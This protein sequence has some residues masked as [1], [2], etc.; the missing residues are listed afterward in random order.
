FGVWFGMQ[1]GNAAGTEY[2]AGYIIEKSLSIDNLFVFVIIMNTFA[3]P[4]RHQ[5]KVLVFGIVLALAMRAVFIAVGAS[6]IS[7]FSFTFLGFGL[8]LLYT[9]VQL[10]RHR[11]EDPDIE[12][13]LMVRGARRLLP[14]SDGYI[15]GRLMARES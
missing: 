5:H 1:Y 6:L 12:S 14:V 13:N 2:F 8:L 9:A 4:D 3:V 10:F 7:M 15:G 11:N